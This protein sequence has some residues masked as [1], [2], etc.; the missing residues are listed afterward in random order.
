V[1][2]KARFKFGHVRI[3]G[4]VKSSHGIV[5]PPGQGQGAGHGQGIG[6]GV[7]GGK[8][9]GHG[10]PVFSPGTLVSAFGVVSA[11]SAPTPAPTPPGVSYLATVLADS[12]LAYWKL[13]ETTG[14]NAADSSGNGHAGTYEGSPTLGVA[15]LITTGKSVTFG[16]SKDVAVASVF[17]IPTATSPFTF[18]AWIKTATVAT[19]PIISGRNSG[20]ANANLDFEVRNTGTLSITPRDNAGAGIVTVQSPGV[21]NDNVRHH[22]VATRSAAKLWTLYIDGASVATGSDTMGTGITNLD[23]AYIAFEGRNLVYFDN[24]IDEVAVY[25]TALSAARV[26]A[27]WNAGK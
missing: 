12:P 3:D 27:H 19:R 10:Q 22:V 17:S 15:P 11:S 7:G 23:L 26:L 9:H 13:D 5:V 24:T 1:S 20:S 18:E 4:E 6:Q 8:D 16:T 21:V 25:Q 14:T 2:P